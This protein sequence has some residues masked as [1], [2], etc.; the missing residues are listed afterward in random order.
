M[1]KTAR[2]ALLRTLPVMAGYLVLRLGFGGGLLQSKGYGLGWAL[3]MGLLVYAGSMQ[4]VAVDLL[5][6]AAVVGLQLWR[7][8][9][10]LS[11]AAGTALYMVLVQTVFK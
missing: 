9:T 6:G 8:N 2:Y 4:Y 3:A 11:I 10:L 5:A 7:K 1:G